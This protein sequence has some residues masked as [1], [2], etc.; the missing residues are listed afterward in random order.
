MPY[1]A[2]PVTGAAGT[3]A[4][5]A[6]PDAHGG[7]GADL[8]ALGHF[9][10]SSLHDRPDRTYAHAEMPIAEDC[11]LADLATL[12]RRSSWH[13][14]CRGCFE[15]ACQRMERKTRSAVTHH[16]QG[17]FARLRSL[18]PKPTLKSEHLIRP[19]QSQIQ[20]CTGNR[21][22]QIA[23]SL[24]ART[25]DPGA[26]RSGCASAASSEQPVQLVLAAQPSPGTADTEIAHA[27]LIADQ[28]GLEPAPGDQFAVQPGLPRAEPCR[29]S[30]NA[31]LWLVRSQG[32]HRIVADSKRVELFE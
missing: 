7:A 1:A 22:V 2:V 12:R 10:V 31:R 26:A 16:V 4:D 6:V 11:Y 8:A 3:D 25:A 29:L 23:K 27:G 32:T 15:S 14:H 13:R 18:L 28:D 5:S 24:L 30:L 9:V 17:H 19:D 20:M 21:F